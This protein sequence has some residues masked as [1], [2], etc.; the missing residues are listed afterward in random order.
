MSATWSPELTLN[1]ADLDRQH[2]DLFR[3]VEAAA[4]AAEQG[5]R[6]EAERAVQTFADALLEHLAAEDA[7]MDETL[8]PE[9]GRHKLAHEM[10]VRDF[11]QLREELREKGPTPVVAEWLRTRIP[12]WL[13]F[14]ILA[15]DVP[16]ATHL[17][18]RATVARAPRRG[19]ARRL[20]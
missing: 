5:T 13:R 20:S 16:L 3:Q 15:N 10:F 9:R 6:A 12:E 14:H 1:H 18:S 8:Y 17:S 19:A 4:V 2:A 7:V 11:M